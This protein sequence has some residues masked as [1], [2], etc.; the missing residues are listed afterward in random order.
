MNGSKEVKNKNV[1]DYPC[2]VL[3]T[4]AALCPGPR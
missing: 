3:I 1:T 2:T 4:E